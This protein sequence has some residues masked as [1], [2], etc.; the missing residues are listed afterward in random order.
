MSRYSLAFNHDCLTSPHTLG[1][2]VFSLACLGNLTVPPSPDSEQ[3]GTPLTV[4]EVLDRMKYAL[5]DPQYVQL[6]FVMVLFFI[7][8]LYI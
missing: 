5:L 6:T 7:L 8:L 2:H 1:S 4:D 3:K